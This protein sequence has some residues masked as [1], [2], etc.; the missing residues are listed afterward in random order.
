MRRHLLWIVIFFLSS[1]QTLPIINAP[2]SPRKEKSFVCPDPFL[3]R[4]YRLVHAIEARLDGRVQSQIIGITLALPDTR[5]VSCAIITVEGMSL[6]EA[7]ADPHGINVKRALPPF[8]S[9][10]FA[11]NMMEDIKLIFLAPEGVLQNRGHL[12]DGSKVCRYRQENGGWIDV[13][14]NESG[15]TQIK[16]YSSSEVLKRDVRFS[17]THKQLYQRIGLQADA[18]FDYF[19]LMNLIEDQPIKKQAIKRN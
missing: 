17:G 18:K 13:I 9:E 4:T 19:L 6:F 8:D 10:D 5:S 15:E 1:C 7:E 11:N 3:K 16:R 2:S 12:A 14:E